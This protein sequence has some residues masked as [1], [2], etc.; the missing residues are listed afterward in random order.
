MIS[1]I[2]VL[3]PHP[4]SAAIPR[5][6]ISRC[7]LPLG[8]KR[9]AGPFSP[10]FLICSWRVSIEICSRG[11]L[12]CGSVGLP[13]PRKARVVSRALA[14][15]RTSPA[16]RSF[17]ELQT[18]SPTTS[19]S[20]RASARSRC[21][22][23]QSKILR[24]LL[25]TNKSDISKVSHFFHPFSPPERR[26]RACDPRRQKKWDTVPP[27]FHAKRL[28]TKESRPEEVGHFF[29]VLSNSP[30]HR[31]LIANELLRVTFLAR[32]RY[33]QLHFRLPGARVACIMSPTSLTT[34]R[35][36]TRPRAQGQLWAR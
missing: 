15:A 18:L 17:R 34:Q 13:G 31:W 14:P 3:A 2:P 36:S 11:N 26:D 16:P 28:K 23:M 9:S 33:I 6:P 10:A 27:L 1:T 32:I 19:H 8:F 12:T 20:P 4:D 21:H 22:T 29:D 30:I 25:K 24:N 35:I 7:P 5:Q